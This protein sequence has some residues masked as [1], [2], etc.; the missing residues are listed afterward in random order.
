MDYTIHME[1]KNFLVFQNEFI[2]DYCPGINV[3]I[4]ENGTGK[5]TL[6]KA[7]YGI[8]DNH[9]GNKRKVN[10]EDNNLWNDFLSYFC[11][12]SYDKSVINDIIGYSSSISNDKKC[13]ITYNG[14]IF[15]YR[16]QSFHKPLWAYSVSEANKTD[17]KVYSWQ[18]FYN[19]SME[20]KDLEITNSQTVLIP[21]DE[22]LTH[23]EGFLALNYEREL[24]FDQTYIDILIK[25]ELPVTRVITPNAK[26]ILDKIKAIIGGEVIFENDRFFTKRNDNI[27]IPYS[28][29]AS[30]FRKLGLL[31]K[32]LRNGLLEKGSILFWDEPEASMNPEL[33]A[34]IVDILYEMQRGGVQIFIAT[35][36]YDFACWF[37]LNKA[38]D[39]S[40]R[41]FSLRKNGN[42][43]VA[44]VA[45]DYIS[46]PNNNILSA[47]EKLYERVVDVSVQRA[48]GNQ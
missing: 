41:Y 36:S 48:G 40:L 22:V 1:I 37:E 8:C 2:A 20:L 24:P 23:S 9:T 31:W 46:L 21:M 7:M 45:D 4:G 11:T 19:N 3:F 47:G 10:R 44:D 43:I 35:H 32:L 25:A 33:I 18:Y 39:N 5:T 17:E 38:N 13:E 42:R 6:L 30:G 28:F 34:K 27:K 12:G 14:N 15:G 26:I 29:E 16:Y